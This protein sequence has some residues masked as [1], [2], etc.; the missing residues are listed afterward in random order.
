MKPEGLLSY[1]QQSAV[2]VVSQM[3]PVHAVSSHFLRFIL[4]LSSH[5]TTRS[6]KHGLAFRFLH[7]HPVGN[8]FLPYTR[9]TLESDVK[10]HVLVS[11]KLAL[12]A[13][14]VMV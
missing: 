11:L 12:P 5:L 14:Y 6:Y 2:R 7:H 10:L 8:N 13:T 1:S 9:Y 4:I 3:N